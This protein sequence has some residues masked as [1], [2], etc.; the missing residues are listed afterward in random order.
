MRQQQLLFRTLQC[1]WRYEEG[2]LARC[3]THGR[4]LF[5]CEWCGVTFHAKRS[6]AKFCSN[7]CR[8]KAYRAR[9]LWNVAGDLPF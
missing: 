6:D 3:N 9:L 2:G 8:Q 1:D 5:A 4:W 7:A